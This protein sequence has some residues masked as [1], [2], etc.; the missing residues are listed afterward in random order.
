MEDLNKLTVAELRAEISGHPR[1]STGDMPMP[2]LSKKRKG[3]L[4]EILTDLRNSDSLPVAV[5]ESG[6]VTDAELQDFV[7]S[8]LSAASGIGR[9]GGAIE[10]LG[11][12]LHEQLEAFTTAERVALNETKYRGRYAGKAAVVQIRKRVIEGT[13]TDRVH[14]GPELLLVLRHAE[15]AGHPRVTLHRA[16]DV[17]V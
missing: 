13:V 4:V 12:L 3:E 15:D 6:L 1:V 9:L 5:T 7:G 11:T 14:R 10:A 17:T 8:A 16:E 2:G